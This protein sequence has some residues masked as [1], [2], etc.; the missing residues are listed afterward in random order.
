MPEEQPPN[1][2]VFIP[3]RDAFSNSGGGQRTSKLLCQA[4]GFSPKQISVSWLK[5]GKPVHSGVTTDKVEAEPKESGPLTYRV[6]SSLVITEIQWLSQSVFTCLVEHGDLSFKKNVS[7]V[8]GGERPLRPLSTT[9]DAHAAPPP[10]PWSR[11]GGRRE[12]RGGRWGGACACFH[13]RPR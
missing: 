8:C 7:S 2:T 1:V 4:T 10:G 12:W 6:T 9:P 3:P 11:G 13:G 5:D